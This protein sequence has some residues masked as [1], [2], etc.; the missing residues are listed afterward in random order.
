M[1]N[2]QK[3]KSLVHYVCARRCDA[4]ETLGGVKLNKILWLSD[5]S[6]FYDLGEPITGVRYIK[7][8][9]GPVPAPIMP[10][11]HELEA[12]GVL[13][14]TEAKHYGKQKTEFV[15]HVP[16]KGDFLPPEELKIV[17][18]VIDHVCDEH[19]A[20]SV[21]EASHDHIWKVAMDGEE[22]PLFTVFAKAGKITDAERQWAQ[23]QLESATA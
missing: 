20:K 7:R 23:I 1:M 18:E 21:S 16:A 12:E 5:L 10:V 15:V 17:N 14:V 9:F 2:R 11:L 19:T 22:I 3:F 6:A 13:T 4:P 8:K